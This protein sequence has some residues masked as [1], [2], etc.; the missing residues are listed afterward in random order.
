MFYDKIYC[1]DILNEAWRR[2]K[3]NRGNGGIDRQTR[4]IV[5]QYEE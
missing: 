1:S 4:G 3:W 2:A 5:Y